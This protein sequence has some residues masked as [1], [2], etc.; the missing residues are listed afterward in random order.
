MGMMATVG[1]SSAV[2]VVFGLRFSGLIAWLL[3]CVIHVAYLIEFRSRLRVML[4]W[5]WYYITF[6]PGVRLL[7][8]NRG[9]HGASGVEPVAAPLA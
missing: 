7:Y 5:I 8:R 2:A 6:R 9:R 3:W 4:E 1:R